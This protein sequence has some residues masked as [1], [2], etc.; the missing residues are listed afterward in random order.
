MTHMMLDTETLGRKPGCVILSIGA[1]IFDPFNPNQENYTF[2]RRIDITSQL[3]FGFHIETETLDW[4][5]TQSDEAK[6]SLLGVTHQIKNVLIDFQAFCKNNK[7]DRVW[8]Q[9][10]NFDPPIVEEAFNLCG[11]E[12]PWRYSQPR[13]TRTVY[14]LFDFDAKTLPR[15]GVYHNALDDARFQVIAVQ[16]AIQ[17]GKT[18]AWQSKINDTKK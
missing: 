9:G 4:W 10:A 14:D 17:M 18:I 12:L 8:A 15:V 16:Q 3:L 2:E 1:V 13:D 7:V 11:I 5:R 6:Q